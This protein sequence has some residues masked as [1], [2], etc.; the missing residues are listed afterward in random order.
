MR[1][2]CWRRGSSLGITLT[3]VTERFSCGRHLMLQERVGRYHETVAKLDASL[4]AIERRITNEKRAQRDS[5]VDD[6]HHEAASA[7]LP[8]AVQ[9]A[10]RRDQASRKSF[11]RPSKRA[12]S[13]AD[14][15]KEASE[16][17]LPSLEREAGEIKLKGR[18]CRA[19][20]REAQARLETIAAARKRKAAL[21]GLF[22]T[23]AST[24]YVR[25]TP[26]LPV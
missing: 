24:C 18:K 13:T 21:L 1:A 11:E 20:L 8:A 9:A 14:V 7:W 23:K 4:N 19:Q 25:A 26:C 12:K 2:R 17:V 10:F 3:P 22:E 15:G 6:A 5:A 16:D